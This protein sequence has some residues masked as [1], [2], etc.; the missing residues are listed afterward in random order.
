MKDTILL[1]CLSRVV[2][3]NDERQL[4]RVCKGFVREWVIHAYADYLRPKF[5]HRL[6][7]VTK[8]THFPRADLSKSAW[9][10]SEHGFPS[11]KVL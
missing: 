7:R 5:Y 1:D 3:E 6:H 11:L 4:V 10:E 8:D 9:K 2:A